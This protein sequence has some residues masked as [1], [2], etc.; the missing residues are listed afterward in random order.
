MCVS[1]TCCRRLMKICQ[2]KQHTYV[3]TALQR[4]RVPHT[5]F[6][7]TLIGL[8]LAIFML[9]AQASRAQPAEDEAYLKVIT[10][11]ADKIVAP[12]GI[13]DSANYYKVR[14]IIVQQYRS[15]NSL[16]EKYKGLVVVAQA[17][18][19]AGEGRDNALKQIDAAKKEAQQKQHDAYIASL[20]K[21]LTAKQI[22][23]V[24][25]G[26]TY[27]LLDV[28]YNAYT[29]M[30]PSLKEDERKQIPNH[31]TRSLNKMHTA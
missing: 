3:V 20:D 16:D 29:D 27:G 6:F 13:S 12:M 2:L 19:A 31:R 4:H 1:L 22:D 21:C 8:F 25:D 28:T 14:G 26:M 30:I 23:H 10:Q 9:L 7:P 5:G 18:H 11:R 15:I 17:E 24:K